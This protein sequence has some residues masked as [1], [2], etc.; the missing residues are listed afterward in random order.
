MN[1]LSDAPISRNYMKLLWPCVAVSHPDLL[2]VIAHVEGLW[3]EKYS[4]SC[5]NEIQAD[6]LM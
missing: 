1:P 2:F 4:K 5:Q 3:F 6:N